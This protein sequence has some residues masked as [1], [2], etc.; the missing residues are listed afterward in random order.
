MIRSNAHK[1]SISAQC[2]ILGIS[3]GSYYYEAKPP[4]DARILEHAI[5]TAFKENRSVY[6]SRKL[7]KVLA[8]KNILVSRRKIRQIM[9]KL[10]LVSVYTHKRYKKR[11]Q[12]V[13]ETAA[14]NL[15]Q[16]QFDG[17]H[18]L[19]AIVSDLTYVR[20]K[21]SWHYICILLDLYN[22]E[23][24]GHSSGP[25]KDAALVQAAFAS[26]KENLSQIR[27]FH[28]DRGSE[29]DNRLIDEMLAAFHIDRSLSL[30]GSPH[31]NAVAEATFKLMKAEFVHRSHFDTPQQLALELADYVH[32]FNTSRIHATL[33]YLAPVEFRTNS[34]SFLYK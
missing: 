4:K 29:F 28:T 15:L 24:I 7:K 6:G 23:I 14:G 2:K 12:K 19:A 3:R 33:G 5:Q 18:R 13:N 1:Y 25:R 16:R 21:G 9:E 34:L 26:V 22:R 17:H 30:K 10:G 20:V 27:M 31:D 8:R 11:E 32:W